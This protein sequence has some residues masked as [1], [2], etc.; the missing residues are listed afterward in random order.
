MG[1]PRARLCTARRVPASQRRSV[2][3][4]AAGVRRPRGFPGRL[5]LLDFYLDGERGARRRVCRLP[6]PV[7]PVRGPQPC[8]CGVAGRRG[9]LVPDG[10]QLSRDA[11]RGTRAVRDDDPQSL[12]P[13]PHRDCRH[14][15]VRTVALLAG[16]RGG[17]HRERRDGDR[18]AHAVCVR[19][20]RIRHS[21]G[22]E[23]GRRPPHDSTGDAHRDA[24]GSG[25]LPGQY[26]LAS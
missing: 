19:R 10:G 25:P 1:L 21:P 6:R 2:R 13:P 15:C 7:H 4:Y 24:A 12:A 5:G 16:R 9:D 11:R 20:A 3:L 17:G 18:H 23:H 22:G 8:L 14:D 26:R